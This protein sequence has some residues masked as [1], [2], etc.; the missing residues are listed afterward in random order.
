MTLTECHDF[1][2]GCDTYFTRRATIRNLPETQDP[3]TAGSAGE[4]SA[5]D[6]RDVGV[7]EGRRLLHRGGPER[8]RDALGDRC[9]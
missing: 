1:G 8:L 9:L 6:D 5:E 4:V 2:K 7:R 3:G